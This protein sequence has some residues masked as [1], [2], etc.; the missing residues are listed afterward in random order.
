MHIACHDCGQPVEIDRRGDT[1]TCRCITWLCRA[2]FVGYGETAEIA[3]D[4]FAAQC[5]AAG[6]TESLMERVQAVQ[7]ATRDADQLEML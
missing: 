3:A 7:A 1:Y 5:E 6:Y 2:E 4:A